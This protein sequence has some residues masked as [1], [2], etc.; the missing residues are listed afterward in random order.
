MYFVLFKEAVRKYM[1]D[2]NHPLVLWDYCAEQ[3]RWELPVLHYHKIMV[4]YP[5]PFFVVINQ[6]FS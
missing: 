2:E 4:I 5:H 6:L 3:H 1:L